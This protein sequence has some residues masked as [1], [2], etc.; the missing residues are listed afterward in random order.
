MDLWA[1]LLRPM[2][3]ELCQ[4]FEQHPSP[5]GVEILLEKVYQQLLQTKGEI[6]YIDEDVEPT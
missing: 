1:C 3:P 2:Q 4:P 6:R 5:S